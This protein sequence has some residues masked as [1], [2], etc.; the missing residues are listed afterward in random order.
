MRVRSLRIGPVGWRERRPEP[1]PGSKAWLESLARKDRPWRVW[2]KLR[3]GRAA[4]AMGSVWRSFTS[5][6][7]LRTFFGFRPATQIILV[8]MLVSGLG[9]LFVLS[10][11]DLGIDTRFFTRPGWLQPYNAAWFHNH[12]YIP[13]VL[14]ALTGFLVGAPFGAVILAHLTTE[15]EER[16]AIERTNTL[17]RIAWYTFRDAVYELAS[18][19]RIDTLQQT[20]PNIQRNYAE[21]FEA[22]QDY[23]TYVGADAPKWHRDL[24]RMVKSVPRLV[25]RREW[26]EGLKARNDAIDNASGRLMFGIQRMVLSLGYS[27][28]VEIQWERTRGAWNVLDQYVRLQRQERNLKW[29]DPQVDARVRRWM[30]RPITPLQE[31]LEVQGWPG[32]PRG[33][34]E[35]P[36]QILSTL[37]GYRSNDV[38][39]LADELSRLRTVSGYSPV[40]FYGDQSLSASSFLVELLGAI[41]EVEMANWPESARKPVKAE[42]QPFENSFARLLGGLGTQKG[43]ADWE[44]L[45]KKAR[46]DKGWAEGAAE[47]AAKHGHTLP[48]ASGELPS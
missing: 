21:A 17:S 30:S 33:R 44:A 8:V 42:D 15:R 24:S 45:G 35:T 40:T 46:A 27:G 26:S 39:K 29:F 4:R 10:T 16:V 7:F 5:F 47:K 43:K 6:G 34:T 41:N 23:V 25:H 3:Y 37:M 11:I 18:M 14:A 32:L 12:A 9:V 19:G 1:V 36:M 31:F 13:N 28:T 48:V 22:L 20:A 38:D 2:R